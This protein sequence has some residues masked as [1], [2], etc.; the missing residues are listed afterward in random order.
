MQCLLGAYCFFATG[1]VKS[2][3]LQ[4]PN[5]GLIVSDFLVIQGSVE[6]EMLLSLF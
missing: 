6:E 5:Q 3:Q 2:C 4:H 1:S